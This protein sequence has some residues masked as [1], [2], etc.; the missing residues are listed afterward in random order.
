MHILILFLL[1]VVEVKDTQRAGTRG[2]LPVTHGGNTKV[3]VLLAQEL[4]TAIGVIARHVG[5][6]KS[7]DK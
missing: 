1:A 3:N 6:D 4:V 2:C 5:N 7:A